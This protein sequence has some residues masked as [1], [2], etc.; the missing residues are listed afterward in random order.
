MT[1]NA[2]HGQV[3]G[4]DARSPSSASCQRAA[5]SPIITHSISQH[6]GYRVSTLATA[7]AS[8]VTEAANAASSSGR[9]PP[10]GRLSART[11]PTA[12]SPMSSMNDT[13]PSIPVSA[14]TSR[15][16]QWACSTTEVTWWLS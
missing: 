6:V 5:A 16:S 13:I 12:M 3:R 4:G 11:L 7:W 2:R 8:I 10:P 9:P 14:S 1:T 15:Y